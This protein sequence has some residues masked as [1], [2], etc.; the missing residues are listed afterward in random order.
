MLQNNTKRRRGNPENNHSDTNSLSEIFWDLRPPKTASRQGR[1]PKKAFKKIG[2]SFV[3]QN[4]QILWKNGNSKHVWE[5]CT[6]HQPPNHQ[7]TNTPNHQTTTTKKQTKKTAEQGLACPWAPGSRIIDVDVFPPPL[8]LPA[9]IQGTDLLGFGRCQGWGRVGVRASLVLGTDCPPPL[10]PPSPGA[11]FSF[12]G[13]TRGRGNRRRPY[14][15]S[16][17]PAPS[18]TSPPQVP[19]APGATWILGQ[20]GGGGG[21]YEVPAPTQP[22]IVLT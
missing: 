16:I 3:L 7:T 1:I 17:F 13:G 6:N 15:A 22:P 4:T 14:D 18:P 20:R 9:P 2:E 5:L 8:P 12:R 19:A 21:R 10:F 11:F